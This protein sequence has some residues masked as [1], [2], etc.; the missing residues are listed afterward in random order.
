MK[1]N[2]VNHRVIIGLTGGSGSGKSQVSTYLKE[3]G[4]VIIDCDSIAHSVLL[5]G[6]PVYQKIVDRFGA[7][8]LDESLEIN[9]RRLGN[10]IFADEDSRLWLNHVTHPAILFE[11]EQKLKQ[12]KE[13][14]VVLDAPLL[15][16]SGL[17]SICNEVWAVFSEE[18][19]RLL[20]IQKRDGITQV[21][22]YNRIASQLPWESYKKAADVVIDNSGTL[23]EMRRQ[24]DRLLSR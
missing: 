13:K 7:A 23:E 16:E 17:T 11:M 2:K 19:E 12:I 9:R 18:K 20:R 3:K 14:V 15:I 22:A 21:E 6:H 8:L 10:I 4:A 1:Q 5:R 24:V